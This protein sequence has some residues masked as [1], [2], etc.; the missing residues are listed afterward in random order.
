[1]KLKERYGKFLK[2]WMERIELERSTTIYI[3]HNFYKNEYIAYRLKVDRRTMF[4]GEYD[5][6]RNNFYWSIEFG[7]SI[8]D[9]CVKILME[10]GLKERVKVLIEDKVETL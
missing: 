10:N 9:K 7:R 4:L 6:R 2:L 3:N 8:T 1:M 5:K